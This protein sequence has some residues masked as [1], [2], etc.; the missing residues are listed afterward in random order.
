MGIDPVTHRPRTD[1]NLL[2]GIP[3]LLAAAQ[4]QTT[5]CWDI[6]ALRLQAD[7]AKY[8]LL[9]GLLRA[10]AAPPAVD[11]MALLAATN[12]NGGGLITQPQPAAGVDH[13]QYD[14]LLNLPALTSV[15]PATTL[16]AAMSSS[17]SGL[18]SSSFGG[19]GSA[20]AGD[21]LSSTDLGRSGSSNMTAA[22]APPPP[23][24]V[25]AKECNNGGGT[26]TPCEDTPAS[27]PFEG[28]EN[29]NLDDEFNSD[30]WKDLLE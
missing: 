5:A 26:S 10:L 6:N 16:P 21:G 19:A 30:S 8:Q 24:V 27:S 22:M 25:A 15:P 28:L 13:Q 20:L 12:N 3:N 17:F 14:G 4:A 23:L 2:A 9:Q 29:I 18:L 11:L 7:A 1:L